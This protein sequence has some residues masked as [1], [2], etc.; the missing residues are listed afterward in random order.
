MT[1]LSTRPAEV[2]TPAQL[3]DG[4]HLVVDAL[5]LNGIN[6]IYAL[7]RSITARRTSC[8]AAQQLGIG[9]RARERT[10]VGA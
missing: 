4:F 6:T 10:T 3:T 5:K 8:I 1:T 2:P 9:R 7:N